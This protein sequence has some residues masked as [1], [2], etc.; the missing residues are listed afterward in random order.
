MAF[1]SNQGINFLGN[2]LNI[3]CDKY[4]KRNTYLWFASYNYALGFDENSANIGFW[5]FVSPGFT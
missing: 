4:D 3:F 2:W 5:E 1:Q